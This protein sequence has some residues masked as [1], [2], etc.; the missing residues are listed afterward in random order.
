MI[1][2]QQFF[3]DLHYT[4]KCY[5]ERETELANSQSSHDQLLLMNHSNEN[6]TS[7]KSNNILSAPLKS[8]DEV[9][10]N[11]QETLRIDH[12]D[13]SAMSVPLL[14]SQDFGLSDYDSFIPSSLQARYVP[15]PFPVTSSNNQRMESVPEVESDIKNNHNTLQL[16]SNDS[17][18]GN[19]SI[20]SASTLLPQD[21]TT[22]T[23]DKCC[24]PTN[25]HVSC[26]ATSSQI[27]DGKINVDTSF[28]QIHSS[29][30]MSSMEDCCP[31]SVKP[32]DANVN[33]MKVAIEG[34]HCYQKLELSVSGM[35]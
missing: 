30:D 20:D 24:T 27:E 29:S 5:I 25:P 18:L 6:V 35:H 33:Q 8:A 4:Q 1:S 15:T 9:E 17:G 13:S 34:L 21:C 2:V 22:T 12:D 28:S 31:E 10:Q 3:N 19:R 7:P 26:D 14:S 16:S 11:I 32:L 23:E